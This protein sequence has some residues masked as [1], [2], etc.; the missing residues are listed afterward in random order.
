MDENMKS[1]KLDVYIYIYC[2]WVS[3]VKQVLW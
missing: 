1:A 3:H 2:F